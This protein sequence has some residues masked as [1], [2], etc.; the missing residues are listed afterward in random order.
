MTKDT[1]VPPTMYP[2]PSRRGGR[3]AA[4]GTVHHR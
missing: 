3:G 4:P 1:G 2:T